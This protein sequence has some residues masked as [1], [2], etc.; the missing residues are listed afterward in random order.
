MMYRFCT[1]I[2]YRNFDAVCV[3]VVEVAQPAGAVVASTAGHVENL[4]SLCLKCT[5]NP[6]PAN[7]ENMASA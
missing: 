1:I 4:Q 3:S 2:C 6:Y 7:V 5:F